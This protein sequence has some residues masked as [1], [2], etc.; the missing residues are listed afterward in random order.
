MTTKTLSDC[1]QCECIAYCDAHNSL[2]PGWLHR[3]GID[4]C[5][6]VLMEG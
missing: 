2:N 4:P 6:V 5:R 3:A 1:A